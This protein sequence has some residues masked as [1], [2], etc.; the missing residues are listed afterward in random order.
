M[1]DKAQK[2]IRDYLAGFSSKYSSGDVI[3]YL[4]SVSGLKVLVIG[5]AVI[6]EYQFGRSLGRARRE[7]IIAF[8]AEKKEKYAGGALAVA[9]HVSNFCEN[10]DLIAMIGDRITYEAFIRRHL[11]EN[12][13]VRFCKKK[14]SP[15][16]VKRRFIDTRLN[17][18]LFEA[19]DLKDSPLDE[20]SSNILADYL[21]Q[22]L[23]YYD[24]VIACDAGHGLFVPKII[25]TLEWAKYLSV[26]TQ[27]NSATFGLNTINKY[28]SPNYVCINESELRL[29]TTGS[30]YED[31][32]VVI[33]ER[34]E[35]TSVS[36]VM[37]TRGWRGCVM[38]ED[39]EMLD[40]PAFTEEVVDKV[41][42][43]DALLSITSPL[44]LADI[45]L[46]AIGFVGNATGVLAVSYLGNKYYITKEKLYNYIKGLIG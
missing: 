15:T 11:S 36:K 34:F 46:D 26:N 45:P 41:G 25:R 24:L 31:I 4:E 21:E 38:Y 43:G 40:A 10:V 39:G 20:D 7:P 8:S 6:D 29:A 2:G 16:V 22:S 9:N 28:K 13:K 3:S 37:V 14:G 17:H 35:G 1:S 23:G 33:R 5:E 44:A 30:Q 12:V 19:Y 42:A 32:H 27:D 18:K